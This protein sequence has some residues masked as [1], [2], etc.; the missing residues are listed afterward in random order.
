MPSMQS[1]THINTFVRVVE[2]NNFSSA[3]KELGLTVAAVSKHVSQLER[4][5]NIKLMQRTTRKLVL[6]EIG[7]QY[8]LKCKEILQAIANADAIIAQTQDE[9]SGKLRVKSERYFAE[10]FIV[11]KLA[12]YKATYPK[13]QLDL[14][15]DEHVSDL[16][17]EKFDIVFGKNIQQTD[18]VI[19]KNIATTHFTL[20]ASPKYLEVHGTPK[21]PKELIKHQYLSHSMRLPKD[22][23]QFEQGEHIYLEPA[24]FLNDSD[25][26]LNC[27]LN[28]MGIV[29]LQHYVVAEAIDQGKLVELLTQY[30]HPP[31]PFYVFYQP[32]RL[33]QTKVNR[34]IEFVSNDLPAVM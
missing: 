29:K 5:L 33:L 9:P 6:T 15:I 20:C 27:A 12:K 1:F 2:L 25:A 14:E 23:L 7:H 17:E 13:V 18:N 34:F 3:A 26:L 22:L 24:I 11:P 8:Y 30:K 21:S 19:K 31:I 4:E 10:R 28:D 32:E 16:I